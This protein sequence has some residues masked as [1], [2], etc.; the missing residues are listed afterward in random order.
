MKKR[1]T[2]RFIG[3]LVCAAACVFL[4]SNVMTGVS[5]SGGQRL[6][7]LMYHS[8]I[9]GESYKANADNPWVLSEEKFAQ[10]MKLIHDKGYTPIATEQLIAFLYNKKDLPENPVM[11]TFDDGYSDNVTYA[12]PILKEY[13]F[14]AAVFVITGEIG[15][16]SAGYLTADE[17]KNTTDVFEY[18]S[19]SDSMHY[20]DGDVPRTMRASK[21]EFEADLSKSFE[22]PL[23]IRNGFSYPYGKY[24]SNIVSVLKSK[25]V[26]FAFTT[27]TGYVYKNTA[28]LF[29]N[30]L[31]ILGDITLAHFSEIVTNEPYIEP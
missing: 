2:L 13:G 3:L 9:G 18:G 7:I 16:G 6:P 22:Y 12:Y 29:L 14:T 15:A 30:R 23:T 10:H 11:I 5:L 19:H 20:L 8:V 25:G 31:T 26:Q 27:Q 4:F 17:M 24:N 1:K 28:P 21:A